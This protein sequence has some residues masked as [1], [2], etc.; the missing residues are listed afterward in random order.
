MLLKIRAFLFGSRHSFPIFFCECNVCVL[1]HMNVCEQSAILIGV[2][3]FIGIE[4]LCIALFSK[5]GINPYFHLLS[6][7]CVLIKFAVIAQRTY[8]WILSALRLM[9]AAVVVTHEQFAAVLTSVCCHLFHTSVIYQFRQRCQSLLS[10]AGWGASSADG[11]VLH[12][13]CTNSRR[14]DMLRRFH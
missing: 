11:Y 7:V 9:L 4:L 5:I 6:I 10:A 8:K 13:W 3:A 1:A 14:R 2:C 12:R